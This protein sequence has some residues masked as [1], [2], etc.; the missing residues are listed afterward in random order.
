[1]LEHLVLEEEAAG[2]GFSPA[3]SLK[4]GELTAAVECPGAPIA[5][6]FGP[7]W[8][9]SVEWHVDTKRYHRGMEIQPFRE[10]LARPGTE[11]PSS[12]YG[13]S[14]LT[15]ALALIRWTRVGMASRLELG[16]A[17]ADCTA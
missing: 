12:V 5:G 17:S 10:L 1:M 6:Q 13:A 3:A 7:A 11:I 4:S 8:M 15:A 9:P 14:H 16:E 2:D